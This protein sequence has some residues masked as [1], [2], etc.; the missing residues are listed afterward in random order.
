VTETDN[1]YAPLVAYA[2]AGLADVEVNPSPKFQEYVYGVVPPE[3]AR[4]L[5]SA[6]ASRKTDTLFVKETESAGIATTTSFAGAPP[7]NPGLPATMKLAHA[8]C[9]NGENTPSGDGKVGAGTI[10]F[11]TGV[12]LGSSEVATGAALLLAFFLPTT[13]GRACSYPSHTRARTS[14]VSGPTSPEVKS[15]P[16]WEDRRYID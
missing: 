6:D 12:C 4:E 11:V 2:C 7:P 1:V 9:V 13:R 15:C 10:P 8:P 16:G 3:T 14:H 5:T